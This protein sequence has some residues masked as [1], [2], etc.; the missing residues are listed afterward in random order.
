[1]RDMRDKVKELR[2]EQLESGLRSAMVG[3]AL[4]PLEVA[5]SSAEALGR[6]NL[7]PDLCSPVSASLL[8]D[9]KAKVAPIKRASVESG[10]RAAMALAM[11]AMAARRASAVDIDTSVLSQLEDAIAAA[12]GVAGLD[13]SLLRE[14][15]SKV[16]P[17]RELTA[18]QTAAHRLR[19]AEAPL[20]AALEEAKTA[21][22]SITRGASASVSSV[23][24]AEVERLKQRLT[25]VI[26]EQHDE[27]VSPSLLAESIAMVEALVKHSYELPL[28]IAMAAAERCDAARNCVEQPAAKGD[29]VLVLA[30]HTRAGQKGVVSGSGTSSSYRVYFLSAVVESPEEVEISR[31]HLARIATRPTNGDDVEVI[32][33]CAAPV[34][35]STAIMTF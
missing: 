16:P 24:L 26:S 3:T 18:A 22:A 20:R 33:P 5:I 6:F 15:K 12:H 2:K 14:A 28:R 35:E 11:A 4:L 8:R 19:Q 21:E 23:S 10:L 7:F 13:A 30:G 25:T 27:D 9:A 29:Y 1:M 17:L 31:E 32:D 34:V